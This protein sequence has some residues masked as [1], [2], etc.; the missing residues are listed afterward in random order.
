VQNR[1]GDKKHRMRRNLEALTA[2]DFDLLVIGGGITGAG[3]ALD[4]A[5]RGL[6]VALI[7]KGDFASGTS[8]V[9]SKLI[10]GGLR[11]LEHGDFRLVYES[12]HERRRLLH[13]AA[14][15]VHPLRF[16]LPFYEGTRV[17]P[18]KQRLGLT[19]YDL[20]AGS[21]NLRRSRAYPL[22]RLHRDYPDLQTQ[23]LRG[24]AEFFDAQMDDARLCIEVMRTAALQGAVVA[25]Y[26]EAVAFE[27]KEG[28]IRGVRALSHPEGREF[29]LRARQTLNAAGPWS[30]AVRQLVGDDAGPALRP[31]K[32]VHVLAPGRGLATAFLLLH[33]ADGRVFFVIPWLGKTLIGTTDTVCDEAPD[34]I[35]ATAADV[36]YLLQGHNHYFTPQLSAID[37]LGSF[38]GLRPLARSRPGEP[39]AL[40]REFALTA[41]PSGLL[42]VSGGKYTTY[43]RMAEVVVDAVV[44]RLSLRRRCRTRDFQL[45]GTPREPW[46]QFEPAAAIRI[47]R[48]YQL[49]KE[50]A[51][52]LVRRYGLRADNV[53]AYLEREPMLRGRVVPEEP[54]LLAEFAYQRDH[55]MAMTPADFLLRRTRLGLFRP[56]LLKKP[57]AFLSCP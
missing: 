29:S 6:R 17:P 16:V 47:Q 54:D 23:G 51:R 12:L 22:A 50:E 40:S 1:R 31:T 30:D 26:V 42:T 10:H 8:S 57:P 15:L 5:L 28:L 7:D 13:N 19:L 24:G 44:R 20:L 38:V 21:S 27:K 14:H 53:A 55:E 56:D 52:R 3:A 36:E 37:L 35:S 9:S 33:P 2:E 41:S 39:S 43:R 4:A 25:N 45:N 11:Y 34:K 32:G 49:E 18:W 46:E 48:R